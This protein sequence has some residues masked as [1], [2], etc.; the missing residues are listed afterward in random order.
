MLH[1]PG[2]ISDLGSDITID[3][4]S[5]IRNFERNKV[6]NDEKRFSMMKTNL[7]IFC[8]TASNSSI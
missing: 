2:T 4:L 7:C 1:D 8:N 5:L 3:S 6:F